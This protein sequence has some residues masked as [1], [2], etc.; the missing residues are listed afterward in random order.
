[1][2]CINCNKRKALIMLCQKCHN[3]FFKPIKD[4]LKKITKFPKTYK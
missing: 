2:K 4:E 1:M 3:E